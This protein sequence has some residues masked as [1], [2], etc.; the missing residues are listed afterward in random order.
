[1]SQNSWRP[2]T[3]N[4]LFSGEKTFGWKVWPRVRF[5]HKRSMLED[6]KGRRIRP[7]FWENIR[8]TLLVYCATFHSLLG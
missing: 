3:K 4:V 5:F 6:R 1:M 7:F 8:S 2:I